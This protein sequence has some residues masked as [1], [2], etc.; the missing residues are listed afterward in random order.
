MNDNRPPRSNRPPRANRPFHKGAPRPS[1]PGW[2]SRDD[3]P[4]QA[5]RPSREGRSGDRPRGGPGRFAAKTSAP[6][7]PREAALNA[8]LAVNAGEHL[9]AALDPELRKVVRPDDKGLATEIAYGVLRWRG[10]L[11]PILAGLCSRPLA[12]LDARLREAMRI[13]LYQL[14]FLDR[15][16]VHAAV[17]ESVA[18]MPERPLRNFANG[19]LRE[20]AR[21]RDKMDLIHRETGTPEQLAHTASLPLWWVKRLWNQM[22]PEGAVKA[23]EAVNETP[24]TY[25][26]VNTARHSRDE[27]LEI[28]KKDGIDSRPCR[29][30][31]VGIEIGATRSELDRI[32]RDGL[33]FV[34][35]EASQIVPLLVA[36][37]PNNR[38]LD[39]CA[40]PGGKSLGLALSGDVS[41]L[42]LDRSGQ[43]LERLKKSAEALGIVSIDGRQAD[44]RQLPDA[45][46]RSP[47]DRVLADPPCSAMGTLHKNPD[48]RWNRQD[49]DLQLYARTQREILD[50]AWQAVRKGGRLVYSVCSL[51]PEETSAVVKGFLSGHPDARLLTAA[52][53]LEPA[54][55][56]EAAKSVTT[57]DGFMRMTP[58]E[59]HTDGFFAAAFEKR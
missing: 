17:S 54:L 7:T 12:E 45:V 13:G 50:S 10:Q 55:G 6:P 18:L 52:E 51:E 38:V 2:Q 34:Q 25:L 16:P 40:A 43:R 15:V 32:V 35:D 46:T 41:V 28:F 39:V 19:V 29:F 9:D 8:L 24:L 5:G 53:I 48:A 59:H 57:P 33:G 22:G 37:A 20:A 23:T 27:L 30:S 11:D 4:G 36:P 58:W 26:R 56:A 1:R 21:R 44:A 3:R 14:L 31:P 49:G 42:S 47:Y